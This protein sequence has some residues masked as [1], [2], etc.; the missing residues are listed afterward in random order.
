VCVSQSFST[1]AAAWSGAAGVVLCAPCNP[2]AASSSAATCSSTLELGH[3][4]ASA[5]NG[6]TSVRQPST[7][8]PPPL[9]FAHGMRCCKAHTPPRAAARQACGVQKFQPHPLCRVA[10]PRQRVSHRGAPPQRLRL[11]VWRRR[12]TSGVRAAAL[13]LAAAEVRHLARR[14][15]A[16]HC[17]CARQPPSTR[18]K[19]ATA[20]FGRVAPVRRTSACASTTLTVGACSS[21]AAAAATQ[22]CMRRK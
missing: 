8:K 9:V 12:R 16:Q 3:V 21:S 18:S 13:Q 19:R 14:R 10:H 2:V 11:V 4:A 17:A 7:S 20:L 15:R 6:H 5:V 1:A 22:P